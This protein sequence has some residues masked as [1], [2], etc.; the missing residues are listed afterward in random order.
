MLALLGLARL[1]LSGCWDQVELEEMA[2]VEAVGLDLGPGGNPAAVVWGTLL[3][4][5]A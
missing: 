5:G 2:F 1:P 4:R 3:S